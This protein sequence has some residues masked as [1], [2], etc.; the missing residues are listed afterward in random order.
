MGSEWKKESTR[1][2][3]AIGPSSFFESIFQLGKSSGDF[4]N[5]TDVFGPLDARQNPERQR[6]M[7]QWLP[8]AS[9]FGVAAAFVKS[10]RVVE[11]GT[12]AACTQGTRLSQRTLA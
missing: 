5:P 8:K 3:V 7:S 11:V 2:K 4:P 10:E 6:A 12:T 1:Q 9:W